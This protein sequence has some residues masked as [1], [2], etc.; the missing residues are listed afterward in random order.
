MPHEESLTE[1]ERWLEDLG[2]PQYYDAFMS[3]DIIGKDV[4]LSLDDGDL[5]CIGI[6]SLGHRKE[7]L[8]SV[9][10]MHGDQESIGPNA[11]PLAEPVQS[12]AQGIGKMTLNTAGGVRTED[13]TEDDIEVALRDIAAR[14]GFIILSQSDQF[15]IQ[16]MTE[17]SDSYV[18][19]YREGDAHHHNEA[20]HNVTSEIV[21]AV[22]CKYLSGDNS[23][24]DDV[25][26]MHP[27]T[28]TKRSTAPEDSKGPKYSNRTCHKCGVIKPQPEMQRVEVEEDW[29][30]SQR[31]LSTREV[32]GAVAGSEKSANSLQRWALSPGRRNY[33]RKRKVWLCEDCAPSKTSF[34]DIVQGC[35]CL[36]AIVFILIIIGKI[37]C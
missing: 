30:H 27:A 29:G 20:S 22:F 14:G 13:A 2:L 24:K 21:Q 10:K 33:K 11:G 23:W 4:I 9:S 19:E 6:K 15:Y 18:L 1:L 16:T 5:K 31:G 34:K 36:L 26:W 7:I 17:G 3:N 25:Q 12:Q 32:I 28:E 37:A 8:A 35:G